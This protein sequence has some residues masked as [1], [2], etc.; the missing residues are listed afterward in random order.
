MLR[1][2]YKMV[3]FGG[4]LIGFLAGFINGL[5]ITKLNIA[6]FIINDNHALR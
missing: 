3:R 1:K 5:V 4:I 2:N 6:P